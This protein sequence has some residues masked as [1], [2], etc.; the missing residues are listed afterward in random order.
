MRIGEL[1]VVLT[2]D[3]REK[4][5]RGLL[6]SHAGWFSK[7]RNASEAKNETSPSFE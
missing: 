5:G 1:F 3:N 6:S 2:S 4:R 7:L